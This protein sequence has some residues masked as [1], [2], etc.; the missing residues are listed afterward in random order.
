[1]HAPTTRTFLFRVISRQ[2]S[3][4]S[5]YVATEEIEHAERRVSRWCWQ[6]GWH[7]QAAG[8]RPDQHHA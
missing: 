8:A 5:D 4:I 3:D 6:V 7:R 1:M 2:R